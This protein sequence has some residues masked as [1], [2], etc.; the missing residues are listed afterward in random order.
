MKKMKRKLLLFLFSISSFVAYGDNTYSL[1]INQQGGLE[2]IIELSSNPS[3]SFEGNNMIVSSDITQISIPIDKT[4]DYVIK[5][6]TTDIK[7]VNITP[8]F[9]S[10]HITL[11][12]CPKGTKVFVYS[13]DGTIAKERIVD[14]NGIVNLDLGDIPKGVYVLSASNYRIKFT[15]K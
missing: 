2:T 1:V 7:K 8:K 6:G 10:Q 3:I 11:N 13:I 15:N 14:A 12:G 9:S 5:S 4:I